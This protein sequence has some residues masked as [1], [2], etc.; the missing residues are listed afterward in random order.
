MTYN[1]ILK[2]KYKSWAELEKIIESQTTTYQKGE[3]FEEFIFAYLTINQQL[4]Q[5]KEVY[6][7]KDIPKNYRKQFKFSTTDTGVDGLM[8]LQNGQSASYQVKFRTNRN[9]PSYDELAKFWVEGQHTDWNYTIANCYAITNLVKKQTKHLQI[10]VNEFEVLDNSFFEELYQLTNFQIIRKNIFKNPFVFQ[11]EIITDVI[12]GFENSDKG[13]LIAACGTGKTLVA[14]W[15][16]EKMKTT[17]VLFLAPSLALIKQTLD[18]WTKESKET[19]DF[20]AVCSDKT[21]F[22]TDEGDISASDFNVPVTTNSNEIIKFLEVK[23]NNKKVIFSTYQ[24]LQVLSEATQ[25]TNFTFDLIVFDEAHRTAGTKES[26]FFSLALENQFIKAKKRLF[27]TATQRLIKPFI[28]KR[29]EEENLVVFSMDD[30]N[31]YG[32]VFHEYN[33]GKAIE[34]KVI[35]DYKIIIAGIEEKDLFEWI[36]LNKDLVTIDAQDETNANTLFTQIL[37]AKAIKEYPIKKIISFHSSVKNAKLFSGESTFSL[38]LNDVIVSLNKD[39]SKENLYISHINGTMPTGVRKEI[40]D[41][42]KHSELGIISNA[43]C[44]TEGVDVPVIDCVYFVDAKNSLIDIVQACG[45]ALRKPQ[46]VQKEEAYFIVPL[47]ISENMQ[48]EDIFNLHNFEMLYSIVQALREQDDRMEEWIDEIN[49]NV[50]K[51][52]TNKG[53]YTK[54]KFHPITINLPKQF[55]LQ[56]FEEKLYLKVAEINKKSSYI[57]GKTYGK[58]ERKS[59]FKRIFKTLGDY[60]ITSYEEKLV[61][62]TIDKFGKENDTLTSPFLKINH[63]NVSHTSR[64]GLIMPNAKNYE[65]T[66]LGKKYFKKEIVFEEIFKRQLL[67]YSNILEENDNTRLLFPY[68]TCLKILLETKKLSF[69]EFAFAVY[70]IFDSSEDSVKQ[71]IADIT[72][73]REHYP[74]LSVLN[75]ANQSQ[76]LAELNEKFKTDFTQTDIWSKKTT[77]NNQFIYFRNHLAIFKDFIEIDEAISITNQTKARN[78]LAKDNK[79]EFEK[80]ATNLFKKYIQPFLNLVVFGL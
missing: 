24:S 9:K 32:K 52:K 15:I 19:F 50:V 70:T 37:V 5:I 76:I 53:K 79:L 43:R 30:E 75:E 25:Q 61:N 2:T 69:V 7:Q 44:L 74:N 71:A 26:S 67:R 35:A 22:D 55:D 11:N 18:E 78:E 34:Q 65:L 64:L 66:P 49:I 54:S 56:D 10:L 58:T 33:F 45:R 40:L 20:Q 3:L 47:L 77:I 48:S 27:M 62:P 29:A 46:N 60:S 38:P 8:I 63:N 36:S 17:S 72:F 57:L 68:R 42:F 59:S 16:T 23:T 80:D 41:D 28:K 13:K 1:K 4:Y 6:R 73:L 14:L 31:T 39:I 21:V 51:G 12:K